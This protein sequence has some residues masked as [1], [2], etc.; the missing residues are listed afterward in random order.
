[1][2]TDVSEER[3]VSIFTVTTKNTTV[4]I[5][6]ESCCYVD[7]EKEEDS[8]VRFEIVS[9]RPAAC[10]ASSGL[11]PVTEK[12]NKILL[13]THGMRICCLAVEGV[14]G[15]HEAYVDSLSKHVFL[16]SCICELS[17]RIYY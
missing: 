10:L 11:V 5:L 14:S 9:N 4:E 8:P 3:I 15:E 13:Q 12:P 16:S 1:V 7:Y 17:L 2:I 6:K